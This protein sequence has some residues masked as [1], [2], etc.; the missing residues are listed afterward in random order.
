MLM[1]T[2]IASFGL[3]VFLSAVVAACGS[4]TANVQNA[5][6]IYTCVSDATLADGR[7]ADGHQPARHD[8]RG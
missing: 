2:R 5:E 7:T 6:P 4:G 3:L 1:H 8:H